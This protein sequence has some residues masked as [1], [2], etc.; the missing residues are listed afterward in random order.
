MKTKK[1]NPSK[2]TA[3][4]YAELNA[5]TRIKSYVGKLFGEEVKTIQEWNET[6]TKMNLI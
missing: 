6:F 4:R 2:V 5:A 3:G 1:K